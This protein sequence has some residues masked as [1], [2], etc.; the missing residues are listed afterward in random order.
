MNI[1]DK[2]F[3]NITQRK[4]MSNFIECSLY[5]IENIIDNVA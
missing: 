5:I 4:Q 3:Q 2:L 1:S